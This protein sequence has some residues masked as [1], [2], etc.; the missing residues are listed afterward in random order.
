MSRT[1][2]KSLQSYFLFCH[3][4]AS[5]HIPEERLGNATAFARRIGEYPQQRGTQDPPKYVQPPH[6][7]PKSG[8]KRMS[9]PFSNLSTVVLATDIPLL[10][11][12]ELQVETTSGKSHFKSRRKK[13]CHETSQN[14]VHHVFFSPIK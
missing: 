11:V 12:E 13:Q 6:V 9:Y 2:K 14:N 7:P 4:P 10:P 1:C 5:P 3:K 8:L